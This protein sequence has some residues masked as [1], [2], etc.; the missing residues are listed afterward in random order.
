MQWNN[1]HFL[2]NRRQSLKTLYDYTKDFELTGPIE[3]KRKIEAY[4]K[5]SDQTTN[6]GK[7]IESNYLEAPINLYDLLVIN[8]KLIPENKI[9]EIIFMLARFL[10]SY[11]N[12]PWLNLL[13]SICR[14]INNSFDDPDGKI[15]FNNFIQEARKNKLDWNKTLNNLLNFA[16]I[17]QNKHKNI[18]SETLEPY[19]ET[20]DE[21]ILLHKYLQDKHSAI[22]YIQLFNKRLEKCLVKGLIIALSKAEKTLSDLEKN[23][24]KVAEVTK[25]IEEFKKISKELSKLPEEIEKNSSAI[26]LRIVDESNK[27]TKLIDKSVE[28]INS[29]IDETQKSH[30]QEILKL[31]EIFENKLKKQSSLITGNLI[32]TIIL[33]FGIGLYYFYILK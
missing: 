15:R 27:L 1:D 17:L 22:K 28:E 7:Y 33:L 30:N 14:L 25:S 18:F 11:Q 4:F 2:Y 9:Q 23:S 10:E 13:S 21:L 6:I 24:S 20:T 32:F 26:A 16:K 31:K 12:N 19:L 29:K 3:F 5:V 8:S